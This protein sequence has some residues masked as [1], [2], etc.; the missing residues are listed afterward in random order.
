MF[1]LPNIN[2]SVDFFS[3]KQPG[4]MLYFDKGVT[5]QTGLL[6]RPY[7]GPMV[8]WDLMLATHAFQN[9][10]VPSTTKSNFTN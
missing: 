4:M 1:Y 7:H 3:G 9:S 6:S 8:C 2:F 10:Q 5:E